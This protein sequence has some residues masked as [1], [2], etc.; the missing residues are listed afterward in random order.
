MH[1]K[2]SIRGVLRRSLGVE[3]RRAKRRH[4]VVAELD[5]LPPPAPETV[6][7][8]E[9]YYSASFPIS[10]DCPH[11]PE[12]V[13][14]RI[15]SYYWHYTFQFGARTVEAD[16]PPGKGLRGRHWQRYRHVFPALLSLTGGSLEG[17]TALDVGCNCGFWSIQARLAG[18]EPVLGLEASQKNVEQARFILGLTGLRGISFEVGNAYDIS[19]ERYGQFDVVLC[20][21]LLYHLENPV[22]ALER[23]ADVT[24]DVAVI[25]T[26]VV[27]E[28]ASVCWVQPDVVHKQNYSN[29]LRMI[30]SP[31]AVALMLRRAG[32]RQV[33]LVP[34]TTDDLPPDYER[35]T[36]ETFLALR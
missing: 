29:R 12:E 16:W 21:G 8:A 24:R 35:G 4:D 22:L 30:P 3:V 17:K 15:R 36:R 27:P 13:E 2:Q 5:R 26:T 32:F 19:G 10:A 25:D 11:P 31:A 20:L 33:L 23:L 34:K 9:S 1:V 7:Q 6:A 28:R 14:R 18:A